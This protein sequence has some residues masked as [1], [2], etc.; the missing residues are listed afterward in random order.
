MTNPINEGTLPSQRKLRQNTPGKLGGHT[1]WLQDE[2]RLADP[3]R[4]DVGL[5]TVEADQTK[6]SPQQ[7]GGVDYRQKR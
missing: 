6:G 2:G 1:A 4:D 7:D 3:I 5:H